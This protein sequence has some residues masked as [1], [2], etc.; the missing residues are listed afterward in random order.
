MSPKK[1][2]TEEV[3]K[4]WPKWFLLPGHLCM[5]FQQGKEEAGAPRPVYLPRFLPCTFSRR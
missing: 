5:S 1:K 2:E 4:R 3:A